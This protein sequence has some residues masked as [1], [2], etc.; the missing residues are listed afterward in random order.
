MDGLE[1]QQFIREQREVAAREAKKAREELARRRA[2]L[3][4]GEDLP[5]RWRQQPPEFA[6][7]R[8]HD[9][10]VYK[11]YDNC[12]PAAMPAAD[13]DECIADERQFILNVLAHV[14][15]EERQ[16]HKTEID[17][18][19]N[20]ISELEARRSKDLIATI[21]RL[22]ATLARVERLTEGEL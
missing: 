7:Q 17:A 15:A 10:L 19:K 2:A 22:D 1:R 4:P 8:Q 18:L 14:I 5:E 20:R 12:G 3:P 16:R 13:T 9:R 11:S 21:D 6:R